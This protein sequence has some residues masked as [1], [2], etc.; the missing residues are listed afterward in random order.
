MKRLEDCEY[1]PELDG[2]GNIIDLDFNG[3]KIACDEE[4]MFEEIAPYVKSGS[5]V[6]MHG[7]DGSMWRWVFRDGKCEEIQA[8]IVWPDE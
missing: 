7:K 6:E 4:S 3:F 8:G 2:Y 5:H 1:V